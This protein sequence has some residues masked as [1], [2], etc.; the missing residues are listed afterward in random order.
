MSIYNWQKKDWPNFTYTE[1]EV[2]KELF[3]I[4]EKSGIV[5]GMLKAIPEKVQMETLIDMVVSEAIKTS[6]IEGELLNR[7][8]VKSSVV[9]NLGLSPDIPV[10]DKRAQGI[11]AMMIKM[12]ST[13]TEPLTE[14]ELFNW[15]E[16]LMDYNPDIRRGNWRTGKEPMRVISG[17]PG[18]IRVH[19]EA[20]PANIVPTEM[21]KFIN[22]FNETAPGGKDEIIKPPVR[23][24]IAHLYFESIHPFEDGNG[25]IGRIISEKALSQGMGRPVLLSLS[26]AIESN[27]KK[28]YSELEK[29]QQTLE[30]TNWIKYFVDTVLIAHAD[31][32]NEINFTLK[33]AKFFDK[34]KNQLNE[35][36]LKIIKRMLDE[37]PEEFK[38]GM[39]A[40][41]YAH[42][43]KISKATATR[44]LQYLTEI[45]AFIVSGGGRSTSYQ[46][47][48]D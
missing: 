6:A 9:K 27:R 15:H 44:D 25:R 23:S 41:K 29:A 11:G 46:V 24:A 20:P 4:T 12:R 48:L 43:C 33:K 42:I 45:K 10:K 21:R 2:E 32:E 7:A 26:K 40:R 35:R 1:N 36:Q 37:G 30:I 8:D 31:A 28:Y 18:K 13:Y 3:A 17:R 39:N 38:G 5:S 14:A 34:F 19:F 47:N 22:W 16:L